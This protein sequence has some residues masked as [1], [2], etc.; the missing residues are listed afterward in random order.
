MPGKDDLPYEHFR[1]VQSCLKVVWSFFVVLFGGVKRVKHVCQIRI[2]AGCRPM[3]CWDP[4]IVWLVY[5]TIITFTFKKYIYT[6]LSDLCFLLHLL[7]LITAMNCLPSRPANTR[8]IAHRKVSIQPLAGSIWL[9]ECKMV[10]IKCKLVYTANQLQTLD[11]PTINRSWPSYTRSY[12]TIGHRRHYDSW[13]NGKFPTWLVKIS[14][15]E[16]LI[17]GTEAAQMGLVLRAVP[18][19]QC[20]GVLKGD[21]S[22][23]GLS[24]PWGSISV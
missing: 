21:R 2:L 16:D 9:G 15:C 7:L 17:T 5:Y 3:C 4:H 11:I 23:G 22:I 19:D 24:D 6:I 10:P 8:R 12:P 14:L 18:V 1:R 13:G 20:R